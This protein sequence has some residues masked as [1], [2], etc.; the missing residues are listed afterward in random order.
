MDPALQLPRSK[1][2][3][4]QSL[5]ILRQG[6]TIKITQIDWLGGMEG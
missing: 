4:T 6:R 3:L 1:R 2:L 5:H